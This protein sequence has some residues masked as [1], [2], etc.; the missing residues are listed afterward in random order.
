M[1]GSSTW[2]WL[3]YAAKIPAAYSTV[4]TWDTVWIWELQSSATRSTRAI[5]VVITGQC[6]N[7][8]FIVWGR[9]PEWPK[10]TSL[11]AGSGGMP[12]RKFFEMNMRWDAIWCILKHKF[13]KCYRVCTDLVASGWFFR[14]SY[15]CTV[16]ITIFLGVKARHFFFFWGGS[17]YPWNTLDRT[18][19]AC[20]ESWLELI[21]SGCPHES[22][23]IEKSALTRA[24]FSVFEHLSRKNSNAV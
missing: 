5:P 2:D 21:R 7:L 8:G 4:T 12:P 17:F 18:L 13:E 15:L 1:S 3:W 16:M 6:L 14:Y 11:K 20:L 10:A 9:R 24:I 22:R 19:L 23:T